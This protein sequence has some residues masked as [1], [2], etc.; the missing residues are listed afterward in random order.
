[1]ND[2]TLTISSTELV[3]KNPWYQIRK[4]NVIREDGSKGEFYIADTPGPGIFVAAVNDKDQLY[5]VKQF[6]QQTKLWSWEIPGGNGGQDTPKDAALREL[7]EETGL[8]AKQIEE[9]GTFQAMNGMM[10]EIAHVF[11]A[12][13]LS[14]GSTD[15]GEEEV[16]TKT[17]PFSV[18]DIV[19]LIASGEL[20]DGQ[21]MAALMLVLPY[22]GFTI[23]K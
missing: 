8:V 1:M 16:I 17:Q 18:P 2:K 20:S 12:R 19:S 14:Q 13:K 10:S 15:H 4:E 23:T 21:S 3:H 9:V 7:H 22:L 5:L 11:V 6:R